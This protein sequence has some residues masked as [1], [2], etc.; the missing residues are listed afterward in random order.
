MKEFFGCEWLFLVDIYWG[1]GPWE[2][3]TLRMADRNR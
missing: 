3:R 2:W 1:R